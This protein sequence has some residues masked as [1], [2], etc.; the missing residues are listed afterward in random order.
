MEQDLNK[1]NKFFDKTKEKIKSSGNFE[2]QFIEELKKNK[3]FTFYNN[4]FEGKNSIYFIYL[5]SFLDCILVAVPLEIFSAFYILK[6]RAVK[7]IPYTLKIGILSTLGA[8]LI[9]FIGI[10]FNE[11]IFKFFPSIL[12]SEVYLKF[13]NVSEADKFL[14]IF[15][16]T[17]FSVFFLGVF[18]SGFFKFGFIAFVLAVFTSR[19]IRFLVLNF[20][21]KKY[22]TEAFSEDR[23]KSFLMISFLIFV[24][25][26][27]VLFKILSP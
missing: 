5:F 26:I 2:E 6:N 23:R 16:T 18:L 19:M 7:I 24:F 15:L 3:F 22:G 1:K 20:L 4:Y 12:E 8:I 21:I 27:Y 25:F 13:L 9:Y 11:V 10:Y 14:L 17:G